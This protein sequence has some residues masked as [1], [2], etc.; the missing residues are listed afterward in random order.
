MDIE[1]IERGVRDILAGI[2][3]DP[4]RE[5]LVETPHRVAKMYAEM[6]SATELSNAAIAQ[7]Y[8]KSFS[9]PTAGEIVVMRDIPA[10]SFCEHHIALMYDMRISIGY[11]P[12]DRVLG[13]SKLARIADAVCRRL[14]LQE[15]IGSDI[16]EII[17]M[18]TGA[19][20]VAV[21]IEGKHSCMTARGVHRDAVTRTV[22]LR[23][24]RTADLVAAI[25]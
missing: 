15:R 14:Q 9:V 4:E 1:R 5:G 25:G 22:T 12:R 7:M 3:E 18:A 16:A 24:E 21:V 13:L 20:D 8:A 10:F 11:R 2:G 23:G 6:L 19:E 17:Q